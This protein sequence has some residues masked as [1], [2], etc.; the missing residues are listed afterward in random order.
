MPIQA[1]PLDADGKVTP[2]DHQEIF[3]EDILI[4]RISAHHIKNQ[5]I[6]SMAFQESTDGT[7]MS[8]DIEKLIV[9]AGLDARGFVTSAEFFCSVQFTTEVLRGEGLKVGY[10]PIPTNP[11]H[12]A[13][14]GIASR[15]QMNR[16]RRLA[17]WYVEGNGITLDSA[18]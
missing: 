13:V 14:W 9:E 10:Y 1:P 7:G 6:S 5:R 12:G 17:Q 15:G 11:Y 4:R 3:P 8:V 2:H 18:A 16:L